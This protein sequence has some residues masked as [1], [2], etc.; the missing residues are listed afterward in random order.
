VEKMATGPARDS[1]GLC[2]CRKH[3]AFL[4]S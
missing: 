1:A 3:Y 2:L 4:T